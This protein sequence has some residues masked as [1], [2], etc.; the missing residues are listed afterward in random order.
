M[1][2][3]GEVRRGSNE[4][5]QNKH[6][7]IFFYLSYMTVGP[8]SDQ[9]PEWRFIPDEVKQEIG[10]NFDTDGEFWMSFQ[11]WMKH[12]DRVEMCNLSPD[13]L[14]E[15]QISGGKKKWEMSVFEGEWVHGAT[16]GGCRNYL[17]TFWHNPQYV[18]TV[19]DPDDND[20][21]GNC[22]IIVA[23]MQK[24]RRS[25][26]NMGVECLTIGFAIYHVT[27]RDLMNKPLKMNF[28]KYNASVARSPAFINLREVSTFP[29]FS[30]Q[31]KR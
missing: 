17:E 18:I 29:S 7:F 21:D 28:F 11:D 5:V 25:R 15:E 20:D 19:E 27:E 6:Q 10:L 9:S 23:L 1:K 16:A 13:S 14:S 22:T 12:F 3:N 26:Q 31:K 30:M 4:T 2:P 24:N 8:W